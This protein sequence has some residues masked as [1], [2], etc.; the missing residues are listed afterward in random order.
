MVLVM[1]KINSPGS[2][3]HSNALPQEYYDELRARYP[4]NK[5]HKNI[6]CQHC[7]TTINANW[8]RIPF[9]YEVCVDTRNKWVQKTLVLTKCPSCNQL[10][11]YDCR[12][13]GT[14]MNDGYG[15]PADANGDVTSFLARRIYPSEDKFKT[16][17]IEN[18]ITIGY[19]RAVK[20]LKTDAGI[21]A[22]LSRKLLEKILITEYGR[23]EYSLHQ[24]IQKFIDEDDAPSYIKESIDMLREIGNYGA[25]YLQNK[26]T[27]KLIEVEEGEA[28]WLLE[29]L[30][31]L[32]DH[33][34]V[35]PV[36]FEE[37]KRAFK[38]RVG[39]E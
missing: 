18:D 1:N 16:F 26:D 21:T 20:L 17:P 19:L 34:Y 7:E 36:L 6:E 31:D 33:V 11:I 4:Q 13:E 39:R 32:I 22:G 3:S 23:N 10:T 27:S 29:V 35:K 30:Y 15:N 9:Y 14:R 24:K 38:T 12:H 2:E 8:Y 5:I 28:A 37:R 25:H